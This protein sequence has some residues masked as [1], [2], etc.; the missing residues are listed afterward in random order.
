MIKKISIGLLV[1]IGG[2]LGFAATRPDTYE[3]TRTI[4]VNAPGEIVFSQIGNFKNWAQW[5]PWEKLDPG[6]QKTF[7]GPETGVGASYA[8][9]GNDQVGKGKMTFTEVTAPRHLTI[10]LEFIEPFASIAETSFE[11]VEKP[12]GTA[13]SWLMKGSNNFMGKV[14]GLFMDMEG[15]IGKDF[16]KGLESLKNV[17]E[18]AALKARADAAAAEAAKAAEAARIAAEAAAA[19]AAAVSP[20]AG[21]APAKR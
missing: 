21:V 6:M 3:V 10:K 15:M 16:E 8:W 5:S 17:S 12:E 11:V 4:T 20:D 19:A 18:A 1:L 14:F 9:A 13:T 2:V 7:E